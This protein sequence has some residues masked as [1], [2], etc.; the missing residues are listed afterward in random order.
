MTFD[1]QTV[2]MAGAIA[3]IAVW[4]AIK[5]FHERRGTRKHKLRGNP[6]RCAENTAKIARLDDRV[7]KIDIKLGRIDERI[8]EA[9]DDIREIKA[10]L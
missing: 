6:E 4:N 7:N 10:R 1:L 5:E 2:I 9:Q 3:I 8:R